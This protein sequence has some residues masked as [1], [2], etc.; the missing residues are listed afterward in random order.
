MSAARATGGFGFD[1]AGRLAAAGAPFDERRATWTMAPLTAM[2]DRRPN[3]C[4]ASPVPSP[5][6]GL[7]G[8]T[9]NG[10]TGK[11]V[12][13]AISIHATT[14]ATRAAD[15][16]LNA[17]RAAA[18]RT[19]TRLER[20]CGLVNVSSTPADASTRRS[21]KTARLRIRS[22][23]RAPVRPSSSL[24]PG[25]AEGVR[26]CAYLVS[27]FMPFPFEFSDVMKWEGCGGC[28]SGGLL[29]RMP[30]HLGLGRSPEVAEGV[31]EGR[32]RHGARDVELE[33][34]L[35]PRVGDDEPDPVGRLAPEERDLEAVVVAARELS[36]VAAGGRRCVDG[37]LR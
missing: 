4:S 29:L 9:S 7:E 10:M 11:N 5:Q 13:A 19:A 3:H 26:M 8:P 28:L 18:M 14:T 16:C 34:D 36:P 1:Q 37:G 27:A 17:T 32:Q 2:I 6:Y 35:E 33:I 15:R 20:C 24:A 23:S 25:C 22:V 31:V 30:E 12:N 21:S